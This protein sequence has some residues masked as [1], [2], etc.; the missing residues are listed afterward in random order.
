VWIVDPIDGT[1][2]FVK[3]IPEWAVSIGLAVNREAVAGGVLNPCTGELFL[4]SS[5]AGMRVVHVDGVALADRANEVRCLSVSRREHKD[6]K[7]MSFEGDGRT[8]RP[9]GSIAYRLARVAAGLDA[10][11]CTFETRSEWDIAAG[12]AL[13]EASGGR[14]VTKGERTIRFNN[15]APTVHSIFAFGKDC[16]VEITSLFAGYGWDAETAPSA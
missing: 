7:W 3:G 5:A 16:P 2:E 14:V 1:R 12:V 15:E 9:I 10:A 8:I 11:T 4:G 6:G 13:V